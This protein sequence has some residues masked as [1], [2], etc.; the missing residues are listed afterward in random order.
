M[1]NV[2]LCD[3]VR[4]ESM[5]KIT[6]VGVLSGDILVPGFPALIQMGLYLEAYTQSD[7]VKDLAVEVM[8]AD[9]TV[10]HIAGRVAVVT[11]RDPIILAPASFALSFDGP[12]DLAVDLVAEG[13]R[14]RVLTKTVRAGPEANFVAGET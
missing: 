10:L 11:A 9:E 13:R 6:L 2:L 14:Q 8:V 4:Q 12:A 7:G 5:G 1:G 3:A